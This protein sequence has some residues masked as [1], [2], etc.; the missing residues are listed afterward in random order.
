MKATKSNLMMLNIIFVLSIVIANV[1]GCKVVDFGWKLFGLNLAMSGGALTYA[2]TFLCTDIIG[3]MWGKEEAGK[4][5][6]RGIWGQLFALALII[7]T[8]YLPT[9]DPEMQAAYVKLLGQTPFFVAGSLVAYFCSQ[10]W[11]V[12]LFHK[13][14][15]KWMKG[16]ETNAARWIWN[17]ASTMTSQI[18]DTAIYATISFGIGLGWLWQP[19]G[20]A[21]VCGIILGQYFLKLGLA[22]IDTPIF[23]LLTSKQGRNEEFK[24]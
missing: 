14:R 5:V 6:T 15:E 17:N 18:I 12:W 20:I 10:K 23:Y 19:G 24:K 16:H 4:A 21:Q 9:K 3:E 13:I 22:A 8:R 11:D 2:F 1:V 7:G